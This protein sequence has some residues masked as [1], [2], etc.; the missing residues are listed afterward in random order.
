MLPFGI[1][2][3]FFFCSYIELEEL[4][5]HTG[6]GLQSIG[7]APT[8]LDPCSILI[9]PLGR[10][11]LEW[12]IGD[13]C[14]CFGIGLLALWLLDMSA[15]PTPLFPVPRLGQIVGLTSLILFLMLGLIVFFRPLS[16]LYA[17]W[18]CDQRDYFSNPVSSDL[19]FCGLCSDWLRLFMTISGTLLVVGKY[20]RFR[21]GLGYIKIA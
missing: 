2:F 16:V 7:L 9:S 5:I 6:F 21:L 20:Y 14:F 12:V 1:V 10:F 3:F 19:V 8:R 18:R 15:G 4:E 17:L 11:S 13:S